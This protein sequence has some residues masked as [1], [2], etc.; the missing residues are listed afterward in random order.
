[1]TIFKSPH[2]AKRLETVV[3][4]PARIEK[5]FDMLN[6]LTTDGMSDIVAAMSDAGMTTYEIHRRSGIDIWRVRR[7]LKEL[8]KCLLAI[9]TNTKPN[10]WRLRMDKWEALYEN[11]HD[12]L[13]YE[14]PLVMYERFEKAYINPLVPEKKIGEE[15]L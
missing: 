8:E 1:M 4:T 14:R 10:I 12:I 3:S 9:R 5:A 11:I 7:Y 6:K 15:V 2:Q 13:E